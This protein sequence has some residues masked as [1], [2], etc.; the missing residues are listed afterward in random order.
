M[1]SIRAYAEDDFDAVVALWGV[2]WRAT[3]TFFRNPQ[4]HTLG[5]DRVYF[6]NVIAA[7]NDLYVAESDGVILGYL[8]LQG[9]FID[10]LYVAL[11]RQ[12]Q[13]VGT[14]LL[15]HAKRLSPAGLRLFTHQGNTGACRFYEKH[16]FEA[17]R[18]G[19]SPPPESEPDVG[20]VWKPEGA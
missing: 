15:E 19:L 14:A 8:A 11:E 10:R 3:Y 18:Y 7:E 9:D 13:G 6:R 16:A 2:T 17:I 20:Y 1:I 5:E 12:R 4:A